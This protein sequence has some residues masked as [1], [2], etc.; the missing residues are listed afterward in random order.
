MK[1]FI[2]L[3]VIGEPPRGGPALCTSRSRPQ[4]PAA[5]APVRS[6]GSRGALGAA[7]EQTCR[8][9]VTSAAADV[10]KAEIRNGAKAVFWSFFW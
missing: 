9:G 7:L 10:L 8:F 5:G 4:S 3:G 2:R 1:A 6:V